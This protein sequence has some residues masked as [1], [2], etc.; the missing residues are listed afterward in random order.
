MALNGLV[1]DSRPLGATSWLSTVW[2]MPLAVGLLSFAVGAFAMRAWRSR[3]ARP[4]GVG[5]FGAAAASMRQ[6]SVGCA[7]LALRRFGHADRCLLLEQWVRV[8]LGKDVEYETTPS[9]R[10][11]QSIQSEATRRQIL[12]LDTTD[13][14][15]LRCS[16]KSINF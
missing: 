9:S 14:G 13:F 1:R 5:L 15:A 11:P 3:D 12:G 4:L 6:V 2:G 8:A 10:H 7:S 16:P